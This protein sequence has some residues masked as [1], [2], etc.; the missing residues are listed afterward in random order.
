M[1]LT[2]HMVCK[3]AHGRKA[4]WTPQLL[5]VQLNISTAACGGY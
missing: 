4:G 3:A 5:V 1:L 2:E